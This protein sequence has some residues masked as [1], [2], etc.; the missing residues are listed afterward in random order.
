M[1][2]AIVQNTTTVESPGAPYIIGESI[3]SSAVG[4]TPAVPYV[5]GVV[6]PSTAPPGAF[7]GTLDASGSAGSVVGFAATGSYTRFSTT[8]RGTGTANFTN[9]VNSIAVV[10]YG[11]RHRRFSV[12]DVQSNNPYVL[13]ARLR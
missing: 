8:G 5:V 7:S 13:G 9:G 1:G 6:T 4:V 12:L 2:D 3:G 10:I 11:N